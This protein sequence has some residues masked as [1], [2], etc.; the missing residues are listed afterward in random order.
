ML[1]RALRLKDK[2]DDWISTNKQDDPALAPY[3]FSAEEWTHIC[4]LAVLLRPYALFTQG[5]STQRSL[6]ITMVWETHT[7]IFKHLEVHDKLLR[8]KHDREVCEVFSSEV[9]ISP[10]PP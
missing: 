9:R 3:A 6:T 2:T 7:K 10:T 4:Y 8:K 5:L 1:N